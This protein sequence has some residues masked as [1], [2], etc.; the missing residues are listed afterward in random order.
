MKKAAIVDAREAVL[1]DAPTPRPKEDWALVK[2]HTAPMCTEYKS[3]LSGRRSEFLGHEAIGE[4]VEVAQPCAVAPGDRVV[5]H[6]GY[7]CG[8]CRLCRSGDHLHCR[9]WVDFAA[10]TGSPEGSATY[11]QHLLKPSWLLTP[12]PEDVTY[13]QA[14]VALCGLG[15]SFAGL[16]AMKVDAFDTVLITGAGPVGLGG[17]VNARFR[18]ARVI[19]AESVAV[20][21]KLAR[22]LGAD[23]VVDPTDA[24]CLDAIRE[25]TGGVGVDKALDCA[26]VPAAHRLCLDAAGPKGHIA[27]VGECDAETTLRVSPDLIRRGL[28]IHATWHYNLNDYPRVLQVI[29][30]SP[31]VEKLVTHVL[32]MSQVQQAFEISASRQC[33]K[34][35]LHPWE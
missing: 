24:G 5:V 7:T 32:P 18:G 11:A 15:P 26:G 30:E 14:G 21:Q 25:A 4:V 20:R 19:V 6:P 29:R 3:W 13:D 17:I 8:N 10:F 28:T 12:I 34:V 2:V 33:G 22:E 9:N 1:M 23:L 16:E 35:L 27:F 31:V